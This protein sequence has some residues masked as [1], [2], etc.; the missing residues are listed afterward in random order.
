MGVAVS[1]WRLASAVARR[2][3]L[4]VVS[5][6]ALDLVLARRL[7][8]GDPDGSA[9]RAMAAF[10][11]P[12]RGR[13]RA[14]RAT[15][16]RRPRAARRTARCRGPALRPQPRAQELTVLAN[17]VEVWLAKEGHDGPVGINY[18]EKI[19][20]ATPA[21]A[22]GAMLA[23][24]DAVLMGAGIPRQLPAPARRAC[25]AP[26]RSGC[27]STSPATPAATDAVE[28]DPAD[29]LGPG[30]AAAACA[31]PLFLAIVSS[32]VLA[33][34]LNR[35]ADDP[36]GR[37]RRRRPA[38]R[39]P[40]RAAARAR[41]R[42]TTAASPSTARAT[43]PTWPRSRRV[44][45]P[46]WL[47][48]G[49]G[50]PEARA[51]RARG[52][53]G[54]RAGR[55]RVR[56]QRRVG[57]DRRDPRAG[58]ST[59]CA[60]ARSRCSPTPGSPTGFPFKVAQ[61]DGSLSDR[62]SG[63]PGRGCATSGYLRT[64]S[65][66]TT[67]ASATAARPSPST[68]F[69][70]KG[71]TARGRR[72]PRVPVQRADRRRRPR[73]DPARRAGGG[74]AGDPGRRPRRA[75][76]GSPSCT[77][78]GWT[79]DRG[80]RLAAARRPRALDRTPCALPS[81]C[82]RVAD[83]SSRERARVARRAATARQSSASTSRTWGSTRASAAARASGAVRAARAAA[84]ISRHVAERVDRSANR[85]PGTAA[86]DID[87]DVTPIPVERERHDRVAADSPH[88][89][90]GLPSVEPGRS[91]HATRSSTAGCQMSSRS[92]SSPRSRSVA[93]VYW[94][95]SLVPMRHEVHLRQHVPGAQ[96]DRRDLD[97]H[98]DGGDA[99]R[100][101]RRPRT[102]RPPRRS[103]SSAPSPTGARRP[104]RRRGRSRRAGWRAARA[105]CAPAG[106]RARRAPGS[107]RRAG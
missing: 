50:T 31:G 29:L 77:R 23:G 81:G 3:Q 5:G 87:S 105:R 69:V 56:A 20:M 44:G 76:A 83:G 92:A 79:A 17:F 53:R 89:P 101:A 99:G 4:G 21:G 24:V 88:T 61:L 57:A 43:T 104:A 28:L 41:G 37:L 91:G 14:A 18:L 78:E 93:I 12:E 60:T 59:S 30:L 107:P 95:R 6:T 48:G 52:R 100:R 63:R 103:R 36:P 42:S 9:R 11:V 38:R 80:A 32:E 25:R 102:P 67:A 7:Q 40:Q 62:G 35:D 75:P 45:L 15:C 85:T 71:G 64:P 97:H 66:R 94:A 86:G 2:G 72:G 54:R 1:S 26:R 13:A 34:Y 84:A 16:G 106:S 33:G 39:R 68:M 22:Y 70:R 82:R 74:A 58:C 46:F 8:D 19:Q 27:R 65:A 51:R 90:T 55:H 73:P 10:P 96:G 98:A 49:Q 47:A